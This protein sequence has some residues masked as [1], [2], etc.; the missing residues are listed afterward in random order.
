MNDIE[1]RE[2]DVVVEILDMD[3]NRYVIADVC[4]I[5]RGCYLDAVNGG[6]RHNTFWNWQSF[7]E[8]H[9]NFVKVGV[10]DEKRG[11]VEDEQ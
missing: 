5:L 10:W 1:F 6:F 9:M 11:V 7:E 2:G 3:F 8:M 4:H